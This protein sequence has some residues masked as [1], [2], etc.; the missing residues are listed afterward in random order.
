MYSYF[1]ICLLLIVQILVTLGQPQQLQTNS[2]FPG[3][4]RDLASFCAARPSLPIDLATMVVHVKRN[5][6]FNYKLYLFSNE[7]VFQ[8]GQVVPRDD[9]RIHSFPVKL[10]RITEFWS[11]AV[12]T[13]Q[14]QGD[15]LEQV[16][17]LK[18]NLKHFLRPVPITGRANKSKLARLN[19]RQEPPKP[20]ELPE[21]A[22]GELLPGDQHV[23]TSSSDSGAVDM[24]KHIQFD[25]DDQLSVITRRSRLHPVEPSSD[26]LHTEPDQD[27]DG[28]Q[29]STNSVVPVGAFSSFHVN[30]TYLARKDFGQTN[31]EI[32]RIQVDA[33][34]FI[35][36][37]LLLISNGSQLG[38]DLSPPLNE[39]FGFL[40]HKLLRDPNTRITAI[41]QIYEDW[42]TRN[43]YTVVYIQR[44]QDSDLSAQD[45]DSELDERN[46]ELINDRLIFRGSSAALLGADQ[47]D[48]DVKA[49]AFIT[50]KNGLHYYLEFISPGNFYLCA[51]DWSKRPFKIIDSQRFPM[52]A[53]RTMLDNEELLLC[54]PAL[55]YSNRPIDEVVPYGRIELPEKLLQAATTKVEKSAGRES[56]TRLASSAIQL[57][58][59]ALTYSSPT[60]ATKLRERD[61][62][63]S[64]SS[65]SNDNTSISEIKLDALI[66]AI[67]TGS[68][69]AQ[70]QTK[71][72]LR[73]WLWPLNRRQQS[74][75][76][77]RF[78]WRYEQARRNDVKPKQDSYGFALTGHDI[79][80]SYRVYN[81][82]FLI[83]VR[84]GVFI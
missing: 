30:Y 35:V 33:N 57:T 55:C 29:F 17:G 63:D 28:P 64:S 65:N 75:D 3:V 13:Y 36:S 54:P 21:D 66:G 16:S 14:L 60:N 71:L 23:A 8:T 25:R 47:L 59:T 79:E 42:I 76:S 81:E 67:K 6:S 80:A 51:V 72:H 20:S 49:A 12:P 52:K 41:N 61:T 74:T 4:S 48:Y 18:F 82:L 68:A 32:V 69:T 24:N 2:P 1:K 7:H 44:R 53:T 27:H 83:S 46:T 62:D 15:S 11:S 70:V 34:Q 77:T 5:V 22:M 50:E 73:D 31:A 58:E 10:K 39:D 84:T 19:K 9:F 40:S 37:Q 45:D 43:F 26:D 38:P 56:L 78:E